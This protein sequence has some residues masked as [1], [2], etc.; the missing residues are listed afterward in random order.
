MSAAA[1][2]ELARERS[3]RGLSIEQVAAA[4]RVRAG[5]LEALESG[6]LSQLPGPVYAR[7]YLRTYA[8]FLEMDV[9]PLLASVEPASAP[10]RSLSI[11]RLAPQVPANLALTGPVLA[12]LGLGVLALL[13]GLYGWRQFESLRTAPAPAATPV[14]AVPL[15]LVPAPEPGGPAVPGLVPVAAASGR[16]LLVMVRASE[17]AWLSV[18]VDGKP[19]LGLNGSFFDPGQTALFAGRVISVTSGK[20]ASTFVTVDGREFGALGHG[21]TTREYRGDN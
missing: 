21:V 8:A 5:H 14:V 11:G 19:A 12:S 16:V 15:A 13:F 6:L 7:G 3:A 4:T 2:A 17:Q 18:E 10:R 20:G 9:E 1:G